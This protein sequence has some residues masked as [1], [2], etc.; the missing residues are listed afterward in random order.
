[1][2][3]SS[4]L[5]WPA[6][7]DYCEACGGSKVSPAVGGVRLACLMCLL[8]PAIG[9]AMARVN[10]QKADKEQRMASGKPISDAELVE[11]VQLVRRSYDSIKA[12]VSKI[13]MMPEDQ[14]R[15]IALLNKA[16]IFADY[17]VSEVTRRTEPPKDT[18]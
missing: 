5:Q 18:P 17:L 7:I 16:S 3:Q 11:S 6:T 14:A 9:E 4:D 13:A 8:A 2:N 1:M 12:N 15:L 10:R